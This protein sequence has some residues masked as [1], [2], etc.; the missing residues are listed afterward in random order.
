LDRRAPDAARHPPTHS[1]THSP[2]LASRS[3][4]RQDILKVIA[5]W[6][7]TRQKEAYRAIAEVEEQALRDMKIMP[8]AVELCAELDEYRM[9]RAIVTRNVMSSV[10]FFHETHFPLPPFHPSLSREWQPYKPDP[11]S[12]RFIAGE[13]GVESDEL[14]MIGDSCRDDVGAGSN[15]GATTILIDEERRWDGVDDARLP[16]RPDFIVHDLFECR[17]VLHGLVTL[18]GK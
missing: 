9:P 18:V 15:A 12:L 13:W 7:S 8:G 6:D 16:V 11:A 2:A 4:V 17:A 5:E 3:F 14:V 1:P 10:D